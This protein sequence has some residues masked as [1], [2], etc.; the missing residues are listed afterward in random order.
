MSA[1]SCDVFTFQRGLFYQLLGRSPRRYQGNRLV[2][3]FAFPKCTCSQRQCLSRR[4][5]NPTAPFFFE[6]YPD[7]FQH[8]LVL[9]IRNKTSQR[10]PSQTIN[11]QAAFYEGASVTISAPDGKPGQGSAGRCRSLYL[12]VCSRRAAA[13]PVTP[14]FSPIPSTSHGT[15]LCLTSNFRHGRWVSPRHSLWWPPLNAFWLCI[16]DEHS[17]SPAYKTN[18]AFSF[19][20]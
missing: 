17:F 16:P 13:L 15:T 12:Q 7:F 11:S 20:V 5:S 14:R 2:W 8:P 3:G 18:F 19:Q 1:S 9:W 6:S 10:F 4:K